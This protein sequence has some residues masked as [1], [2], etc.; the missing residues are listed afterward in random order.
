MMNEEKILI[1]GQE[2]TCVLLA[3][4]NR[5]E[6]IT[7]NPTWQCVEDA[8]RLMGGF[9][10]PNALWLF[11]VPGAATP[12]SIAEFQRTCIG[13]NLQ[14]HGG[15]DA[16]YNG[17][18]QYLVFLSL[19]WAQNQWDECQLINPQFSKDYGNY[20]TFFGDE[21]W[22][23]DR[24][25]QRELVTLEPVLKVAKHLYFKHEKDETELWEC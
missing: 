4:H 2:Y 21:G 20:V 6:V 15:D 18:G 9:L 13:N 24:C 22:E 17:V 3:S 10:L 8:I 1:L 11:Y 19:Y 5:K 7:V 23:T 25:L 14:I 12:E 16:R